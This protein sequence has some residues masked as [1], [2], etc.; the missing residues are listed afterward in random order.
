MERGED[1]HSLL[2]RISVIR[3]MLSALCTFNNR[4]PAS[5]G[6][7]MEMTKRTRLI[8]YFQIKERIATVVSTLLS[9]AAA[10]GSSESEKECFST[11]DNVQLS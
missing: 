7:Q 2:T 9:S 11:R 3:V 10:G 4:D 6:F 1:Y 5:V 8:R